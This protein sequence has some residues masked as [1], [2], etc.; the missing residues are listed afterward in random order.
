MKPSLL[1]R[2]ASQQ[3]ITADRSVVERFES[4]SVGLSEATTR[5]MT[6]ADKL[7]HRFHNIHPKITMTSAD[8]IEQRGSVQRK[9]AANFVFCALLRIMDGNLAAFLVVLYCS[10]Y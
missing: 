6:K 8:R 3:E 10:A 7:K 9:S 2:P 5:L 4:A 1:K